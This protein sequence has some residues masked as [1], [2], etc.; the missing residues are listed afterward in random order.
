MRPSRII[1]PDGVG[2]LN[3]VDMRIITFKVVN[4][5]HPLYFA[6]SPSDNQTKGLPFT[7]FEVS[8]GKDLGIIL[9]TIQTQD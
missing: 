3:I 8:W 2:V 6:Q 4:V 9:S 1:F 7:S 5:S